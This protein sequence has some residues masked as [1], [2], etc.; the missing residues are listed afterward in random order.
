MI[1]IVSPGQGTLDGY[2]KQCRCQLLHLPNGLLIFDSNCKWK[3]HWGHPQA[4]GFYTE[5]C[6]LIYYIEGGRLA[7]EIPV[8]LE[9][10]V[11]SAAK[12]ALLL[13][14]RM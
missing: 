8:T 14:Y 3:G 6:A 13:E 12:R 10:F 4:K 5:G 7:V 2:A 1:E 9:S 11:S